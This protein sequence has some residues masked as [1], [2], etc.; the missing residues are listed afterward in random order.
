MLVDLSP[1]SGAI[2]LASNPKAREGTRP[3]TTRPGTLRAG[4]TPD[5]GPGTL[6]AA[7]PSGTDRCRR[8]AP[9][10]AAGPLHVGDLATVV[11]T[12]PDR[13]VVDTLPNGAGDAVTRAAGLVYLAVLERAIEWATQ[14]PDIKLATATRAYQAMNA[15]TYALLAKAGTPREEQS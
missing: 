11:P 8:A 15:P 10:F 1:T 13:T 5:T 6:S 14:K 2:H 7:R 4:I 9:L 12:G 3:P